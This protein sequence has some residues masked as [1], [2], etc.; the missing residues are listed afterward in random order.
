MRSCC[1]PNAQRRVDLWC[2]VSR[3]AP[4]S[5]LKPFIASDEAAATERVA[6]IAEA[7]GFAAVI[8]GPLRLARHL[9]AMAHLNIAIAL[10]MGG[11]TQ[12]AFVF[13]RVD[14]RA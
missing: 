4:R 8:V 12:A 3:Q 7:I 10:G 1:K 13:E 2:H 14:S 11:G 6:Q 5:R 9:E